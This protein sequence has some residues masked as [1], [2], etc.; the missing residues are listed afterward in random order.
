M[1][2][3][4]EH[5]SKIKTSSKAVKEQTEEQRKTQLPALIGNL[6]RQL[7]L[8]NRDQKVCYGVTLSQC[9]VLETLGVKGKLT[10]NE[11]SQEQGV[12]LSTM[13]RVVDVLVR[14][15]IVIRDTI[16]GDRRKV[17]I[18]LTEK[19]KE[20]AEKL[21]ICTE[22]FVW[23]L[24]EKIPEEKREQVMDSMELLSKAIESFNYKCCGLTPTKE[25]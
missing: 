19:G 16:P 15:N 6:I 22:E 14:D 7:N 11:L 10:M 17:F 21:R 20:L 25:E 8:L 4:K 18:D 23:K 5:A 1:I 3:Q 24:M 13:T 12:T 9:Y 2:Q